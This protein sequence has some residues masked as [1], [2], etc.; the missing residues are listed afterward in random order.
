MGLKITQQLGFPFRPL[1]VSHH[2]HFD[3]GFGQGQGAPAPIPTL[4]FA[5]VIQQSSVLYHNI[6]V[7]PPVYVIRPFAEHTRELDLVLCVGL[8]AAVSVRHS[9]FTSSVASLSE[10]SRGPRSLS[11]GARAR[12]SRLLVDLRWRCRGINNNLFLSNVGQGACAGCAGAVHW[13]VDACTLAGI[14]KS[15]CKLGCIIMGTGKVNNISIQG[16]YRNSL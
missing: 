3:G 15:I 13:I 7:L 6:P 14:L 2:T 12:L 9:V 11:T 8:V 1:L 5:L 16:E 10:P 4:L